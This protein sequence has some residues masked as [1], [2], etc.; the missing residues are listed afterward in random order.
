MVFVAIAEE[1]PLATSLKIKKQI[2]YFLK[3]AK[4]ILKTNF[5]EICRLTFRHI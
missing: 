2:P 3:P 1:T 5:S 4:N